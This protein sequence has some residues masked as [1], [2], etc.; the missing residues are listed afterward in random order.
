MSTKPD[1]LLTRKS[2][3]LEHLAALGIDYVE[4][5]YS[6]SGDSGQVDNVA[7]YRRKSDD[8]YEKADVNAPLSPEVVPLLV[9]RRLLDEPMDEMSKALEDFCYDALDHVNASDWCNNDGGGGKM[10]IFVVD[11]ED[12]Y[13][14]ERPAGTIHF[15][16]YYNVVH[17]VDEDY[18]L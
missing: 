11:G 9:S 6:G 2:F 5:E 1:I 17:R 10:T 4:V 8:S 13:G 18:E 3:I 12:E 14:D 15:E 16:H 7:G